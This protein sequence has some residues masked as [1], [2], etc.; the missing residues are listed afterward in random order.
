LDDNND[1]DGRDLFTPDC[2]KIHPGSKLNKKLCWRQRKIQAAFD[3]LC[4]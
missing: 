4:V 3:A 2:L 1:V